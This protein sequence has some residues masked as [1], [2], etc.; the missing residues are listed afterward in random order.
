MDPVAAAALVRT[1]RSL[2]DLRAVVRDLSAEGLNWQ[3]GPA[4]NS[5]AAQ[6]AHV[7]KSAGFLL[8]TAQSRS[9]ELRAYLQEREATFHFGADSQALLGMIDDF[10]RGLESGLEAVDG[11]SLSAVVDW[12]HDLWEPATVA[13][14]LLGLVEHLREHVGAA[15]LTRQ[16]WEQRD[17]R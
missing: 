11:R 9:G 15:A 16:M 1:R 5:I 12:H 4:T 3:P 2:E 10:E 7:L 13:W 8:D 6:I 14:C 17:Q